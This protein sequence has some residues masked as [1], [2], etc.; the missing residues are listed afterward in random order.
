MKNILLLCFLQ[1]SLL[2]SAQRIIKINNRARIDTLFIDL[3]VNDVVENDIEH[4]YF[5][6]L[7]SL[8][9]RFNHE[10]H[11]FAIAKG[12]RNNFSTLRI[13]INDVSIP[14][15]GDQA[16]ALFGSLIGL[17]GLPAVLIAN[18]SS[19]LIGFYFLPTV[20]VNSGIV[21]SPDLMPRN[22]QVSRRDVFNRT[23]DWFR[24]QKKMRLKVSKQFDTVLYNSLTILD[25]RLKVKKKR[26]K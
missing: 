1:M 12:S 18:E 23:T 8:I 25:E 26:L 3:Q 10:K 5:D 13:F 22:G 11:K 16:A 24:S 20:K 17:I 4:A 6:K 21:L 15:P 2:G 9:E 14:E 7:N 19:F